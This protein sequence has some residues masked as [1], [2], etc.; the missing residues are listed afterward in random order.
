MKLTELF[1]SYTE[2]DNVTSAIIKIPTRF[3]TITP[4]SMSS[5]TDKQQNKVRIVASKLRKG[6]LA[7]TPPIKVKKIAKGFELVHGLVRLLAYQRAGIA[8]VPAEVIQDDMVSE[9]R[10][11][12]LIYLNDKPVAYYATK[13]EAD[14]QVDVIKKRYPEAKVRVDLGI[15]R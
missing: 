3:I 2:S 12:Y 15:V 5:L 1:Q 14:A 7:D 6:E 10:Q 11:R 8:A 4:E 9:E 13:S